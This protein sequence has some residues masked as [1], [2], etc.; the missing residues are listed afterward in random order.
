MEQSTPVLRALAGSMTL[1]T[2]GGLT[3]AMEEHIRAGMIRPGTR[4]PTIRQV[5]EELGM[6]RSTVGQAWQELA[7]LGLVE[8]RRR[9]GTVVLEERLPPHAHRFES[10]IRTMARTPVDLGNI[11]WKDVGRPPLE[12]AFEYA[13]QNP[14]INGT[15]PELISPELAAAARSRWPTESPELLAMHGM[16]D[17]LDTALTAFVRPGDRVIVESPTMARTFDILKALRAMPV[18]ITYGPEGPDLGQLE[19]ARH[20]QPAAFIYQPAGSVPS[21]R[22]VSAA[23]GE[24]AA[25]LLRGSMPIIEVSQASLLNAPRHSLGTHLPHQVLHVQ[26]FNFFFGNDV[27]LAVVGGDDELVNTLA[28]RLSFSSRYVSRIMQLALAFLLTDRESLTFVEGLTTKIRQRHQTFTEELLRHG[29]DFEVNAPPFLWI[30][31][32]DETSVCSSLSVDGIGVYPGAF[33]R[34]DGNSAGDPRISVNAAAVGSD[35]DLLTSR[36]AEACRPMRLRG[37]LRS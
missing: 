30:S 12:S 32:P 35:I 29:L 27:R 31:V 15:M 34:V 25:N 22:S 9:G 11:G 23:W 37:T 10:M 5:A 26:S 19:R 7:T 17:T 20:S 13:L 14:S 33:F 4:L 16:I 8:S 3:R 6:S 18:P 2:A 24:E 36:I 1:R 28:M 21:G